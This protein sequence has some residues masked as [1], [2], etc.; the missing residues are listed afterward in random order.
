MSYQIVEVLIKLPGALSPFIVLAFYGGMIVV[1][2]WLFPVEETIGEE[3]C[4][5]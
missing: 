2:P 1:V 4:H 5:D 3:R